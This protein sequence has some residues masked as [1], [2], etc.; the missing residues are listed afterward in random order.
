MIKIPN[1]RFKHY[2]TPY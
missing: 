2:I 1:P